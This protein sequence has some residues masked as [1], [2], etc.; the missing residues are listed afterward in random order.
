MAYVRED[1]IEIQYIYKYNI[2]T[3]Q[4]NLIKDICQQAVAANVREDAIESVEPELDCEGGG[5]LF[6]TIQ[7]YKYKCNTKNTSIQYKNT[8]A[9]YI[10]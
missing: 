9:K 2:N 5:L 6:N 3:I 4:L 10:Q 1:A 7:I 8:D